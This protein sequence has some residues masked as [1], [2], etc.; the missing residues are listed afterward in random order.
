MNLY[1]SFSFDFIM[2]LAHYTQS[3]NRP[4]GIHSTEQ[5]WKLN[6]GD[7]YNVTTCPQAAQYILWY[8]D[9]DHKANVKDW[10]VNKFGGW[11]VAVLKQYW[12]NLETNCQVS[13]DLDYTVG[14]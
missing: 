13:V 12:T 2:E 10:E 4:V 6:I 11:E 7:G 14:P 8:G 3:R 1:K 9:D 5:D